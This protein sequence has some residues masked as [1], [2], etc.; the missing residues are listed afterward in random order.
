MSER[1]YRLLIAIDLL[2]QRPARK[3]DLRIR[4]RHPAIARMHSE[5]T[6]PIELLVRSTQESRKYPMPSVRVAVGSALLATR[7]PRS[8]DRSTASRRAQTDERR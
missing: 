8:E 5:S 4:C 7:E 1:Y 6:I 2:L 3:Y